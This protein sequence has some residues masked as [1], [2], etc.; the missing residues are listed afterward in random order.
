MR[1]FCLNMSLIIQESYSEENNPYLIETKYY[2][3]TDYSYT[4][5]L[6]NSNHLRLLYIVECNQKCKTCIQ[7]GTG[8]NNYCVLCKEE[9]PYNINNGE[10]CDNK[11]EIIV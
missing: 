7:L 2:G 5:K 9:F 10:K 6:Y 3:D 11:C 4:P 8:N 1:Q